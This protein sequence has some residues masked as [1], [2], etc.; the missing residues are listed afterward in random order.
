MRRCP[1]EGRSHLRL[2]HCS[3]H[4]KLDPRPDVDIPRPGCTSQVT[5]TVTVQRRIQRLVIPAVESIVRRIDPAL[6]E[7]HGKW[8]VLEK[9]PQG[10]DDIAEVQAPAVV[11]VC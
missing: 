6:A 1:L 7:L 10:I 3:T 2:Q 8:S 4:L 11:R 5:G 9:K